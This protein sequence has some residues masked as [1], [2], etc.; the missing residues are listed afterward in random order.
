MNMEKNPPHTSI[1]QSTY[2]IMIHAIYGHL[3]TM[4]KAFTPIVCGI[5]KSQ[6]ICKLKQID[7]WL[8]HNFLMA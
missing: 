3:E 5:T 6:I 1:S 7:I 8:T 2:T 4:L